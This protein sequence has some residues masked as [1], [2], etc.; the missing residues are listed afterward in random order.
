M[1]R[2]PHARP[3]NPKAKTKNNGAAKADAAE[4]QVFSAALA[5][6]TSDGPAES[7]I[8][9]ALSALCAAAKKKAAREQ[10]DAAFSDRT[11]LYAYLG[12]ER[13]KVRKN[14]AR[15]LGA[16]GRGRDAAALAAALTAEQTLLVIP[17]LLLALGSVGGR[18]A[19]SALAA[20]PV[21]AAKDESEQSHI[22][23]IE[24]ALQKALARFDTAA[25]APL[26]AL[27]A[28]RTVL[29][30]A[31]AGFSD[32]LAEE[33]T[34]LGY[35][36]T[37]CA[38]GVTV[39]TADLAGL[40]RARCAVELLL[41]VA[42]RVPC[43][44]L[45]V[46]K[47]FSPAPAQAYRL[48][49]R[50]YTGDRAAFLTETARLLGGTN[51]PSHYATELRIEC[52]GDHAALSIRPC[53]VPDKRYGYRRG[54]ISASIHPATAACLVRFAAKH[55]PAKKEEPRVLDPFCGSGTLLFERELFG[56]CE[57]LQGV[58]LTENAVRTAKQNARAGYSDA[59]FVQKDCLK[60]TPAVPVDELYANL[61]FGNRVGSHE[62]N[63]KL[64]RSFIARLPELI[65]KDGFA[66]LYTMEANLLERCLRHTP[67]LQVTKRL[68]TEAGGLTPWVFL[69]ARI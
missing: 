15:L 36:P 69:I 38:Q 21:P 57:E 12:S 64:Y 30:T 42:L 10:I 41:P 23:E 27:D 47:A 35:A 53:T 8:G 16:L 46:A 31:P 40:L 26:T 14:A 51:N 33:L 2:H 68:R 34:E 43:T 61:P 62:N 45:A 19:R 13:P 7:E 54:T 59:R 48:E 11:R 32:L 67:Q 22:R 18:S 49:L 25:F 28:P 5:L 52:D 29:L 50:N 6:L 3:A 55:A 39:N 66:L 65:A 37:A 1:N 17:S 44:P 63:E 4:A 24:L 56:P 60:F 58:D 9:P 20:Y